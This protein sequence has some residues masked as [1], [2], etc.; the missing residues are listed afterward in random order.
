MLDPEPGAAV[1]P[2]TALQ[3][4]LSWLVWATGMK[5]GIF[6]ATGKCQYRETAAVT[7]S[8]I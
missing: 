1:Q 5:Q 4:E 7:K 2:L 6:R 3:P 8:H